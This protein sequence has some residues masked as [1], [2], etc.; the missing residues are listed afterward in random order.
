MVECT[1]NTCFLFSAQAIDEYASLRTK[2]DESKESADVEPRM[3]AIV[4]R[5]LNKHICFTFL[6]LLI[7]QVPSLTVL[8]LYLLNIPGVLPMGSINKLSE[9]DVSKS[10]VLLIAALL[11]RLF[12]RL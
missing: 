5:M 4:E 11:C 1:Y 7:S 6:Q 9:I 8:F 10:V 12:S 3:E 2:A